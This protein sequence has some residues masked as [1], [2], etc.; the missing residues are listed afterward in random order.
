MFS[1]RIENQNTFFNV[2]DLM[3]YD[4]IELNSYLP[5][6]SD[7]EFEDGTIMNGVIRSMIVVSRCY[8]SYHELYQHLKILP[9]HFISNAMG[10][11]R[12]KRSTHPKMVEIIIKDIVAQYSIT[13]PVEMESINKQAFLI[14]AEL[15]K[16]NCLCAGEY[17]QS[18]DIID[19]LQIQQHPIVV[20]AIRIVSLDPTPTNIQI[21]YNTIEKFIKETE[22]LHANPVIVAVRSGM[23]NTNQVL[24][25]LAIR[26]YL[27]EVNNQIF[28]TPVLS[29]FTMGLF[30]TYEWFMEA[31]SA[32]QSLY[33]AEAPLEDS[34]YFARRMRLFTGVVQNIWHGDCGSTNY[35]TWT[36]SG[37]T[38]DDSGKRIYQGD[39]PN[40]LGKHYLN[41]ETGELLTITHDD[42]ALW[43]KTIKLRS[44]HRCAYPDPH[45]VCATC[46]GGL[47]LNVSR[48]ANLG[49]LCSATGT[50]QVTQLTL[51]N[52]HYQASAIS[53]SF[54][55][56]DYLRSYLIPY[57][58]TNGQHVCLARHLVP[59]FPHIAVPRDEFTGYLDIKNTKSEEDF[60]KLNPSRMSSI[61]SLGLTL[62]KDNVTE[63]IPLETRQKA[64][65]TELSYDFLYYVWSHPQHVSVDAMNNYLV[66]MIEWD[67]SKPIFGMPDMEQ[68]YADLAA[69]IANLIE[70]PASEK[71]GRTRELID[72]RIQRIFRIATQKLTLNLACLEVIMYAASVP[73][74]G[75]YEMSRGAAEPIHCSTD[76][77]T[78]HRSLGVACA[79]QDHQKVLTSPSSYLPH[80]KVGSYMDVFLTPAE[81]VASGQF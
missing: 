45:Y 70:R 15:L 31:R 60:D 4:A 48:F 29:N 8:W 38:F 18:M 11:E 44:A 61:S 77:L 43:N 35:S 32:S 10:G 50:K 3:L 5:E 58:P 76:L 56:F 64:R 16:V 40:M 36:V 53:S 6:Y 41:E 52:K 78:K 22:D 23:V 1:E 57:L 59:Q 62:T 33:M 72:H 17:V 46:F 47:S 24:Q 12:Y 26:G 71:N 39:L 7:L 65:N 63:T 34:E 67:F 54:I 20:E 30:E 25:C 13:N 9:K 80:D 69:E 51:S 37:P 73:E 81:V 14:T 49:N 21:C 55:I 66:N 28:K 79:Y 74:L 68:S 2:R 75:S 19:V 42:P 27:K